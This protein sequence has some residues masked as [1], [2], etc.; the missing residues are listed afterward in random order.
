MS[1]LEFKGTKGDWE[2]NWI[3]E[4]PI[5]LKNEI[6]IGNGYE[7]SKVLAE[8]ILPDTDEEWE[9]EKEETTANLKLMAAAPKL[10]EAVQ[11]WLHYKDNY[12]VNAPKEVHD[13]KVKE[14]TALFENARDKALK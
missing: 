4:I 1:K 11:Y 6:E 5:G 10:L 2:I 12:P 7:Y 9:V 3:G 8:V 13:A 14:M